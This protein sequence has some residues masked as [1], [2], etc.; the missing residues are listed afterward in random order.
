LETVP[1]DFVIA[2]GEKHNVKEFLELACETLDLDSGSV[3][4]QNEKYFRPLDVNRLVGDPS[5]AREIL[6]WE[7]KVTF[8]ELVRIMVQKDFDRWQDGPCVCLILVDLAKDTAEEDAP[9]LRAD[10]VNPVLPRVRYSMEVSHEGNLSVHDTV[11]TRY[12]RY[13]FAS[14]FC[15]AGGPPASKLAS[16]SSSELNI[17]NAGVSLCRASAL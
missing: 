15:S 9:K 11:S 5:K 1:D 17:W 10:T 4:V 6:G 16:A 12:W 3:L 7:P 14:Y 13:R 8:K 2:T